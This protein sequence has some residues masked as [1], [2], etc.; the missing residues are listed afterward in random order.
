MQTN[1]AKWINSESS[2]NLVT[3]QIKER[4]GDEEV[5]LHN[6]RLSCYTFHKWLKHGYSVKK[7]EK[8]IKSHSVMDIADENEKVIATISIP[9]NLFYRKQV[10]KI[11]KQK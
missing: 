11:K 7:G 2:Y 3:N 9:V 6:P 5:K 8:A 4:W 1:N 10:A